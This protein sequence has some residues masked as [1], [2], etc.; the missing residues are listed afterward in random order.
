MHPVEIRETALRQRPQQVER[1]RRMG[2]GGQE[3]FRFRR[4]RR[5][6]EL[7]AV[8]DVA[9]IGRKGDALDRLGIG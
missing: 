9:P 4:T 8:D 7:G 2:V 3:S 5:G 1:G 6:V